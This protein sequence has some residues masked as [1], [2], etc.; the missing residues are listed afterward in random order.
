MNTQSRPAIRVS[1]PHIVLSFI[2]AGI[3]MYAIHVHNLAMQ[4]KETGCGFTE[5]ISCDKVLA[6]PYASIFGIPLGMFGLLFFVIVLLSAITTNPATTL[7]QM[8]LQRLLVCGVGF[9]ISVALT[10]I[11]LA[12]IHAACPICLATHA[13]TFALLL[14]SLWQFLK[15]RRAPDVSESKIVGG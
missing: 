11:S 13:T 8:V 12:F 9:A 2:G 5:T 10:Y 1:W 6:S 14:V 7:R 15:M 3:S 4:G